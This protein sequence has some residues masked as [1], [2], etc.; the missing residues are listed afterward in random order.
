MVWTKKLISRIQVKSFAKFSATPLGISYT[1]LLTSTTPECY[2]R[3]C[4]TESD[5]QKASQTRFKIILCIP[6]RMLT[7]ALMADV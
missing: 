7:L 1:L 3:A 5:V 6:S 2:Q 4:A